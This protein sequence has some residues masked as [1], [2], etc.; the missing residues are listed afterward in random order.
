MMVVGCA[1]FAGAEEEA[2]CLFQPEDATFRL[3][4]PY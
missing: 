2:D 4:F 3:A 1:D